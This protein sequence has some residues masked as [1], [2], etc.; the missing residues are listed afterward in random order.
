MNVKF[1][2][3]CLY[4]NNTWHDW[5]YYLLF[6]YLWWL[7]KKGK[8]EYI[9]LYFQMIVSFNIIAWY[10]FAVSIFII[11]LICDSIFCVYAWNMPTVLLVRNNYNC[12]FVI[13]H[14][15][16]ANVKNLVDSFSSHLIL[17]WH[18]FYR[19][20]I[21]ISFLFSVLVLWV[22]AL[23]GCIPIYFYIPTSQNT[24]SIPQDINSSMWVTLIQV[25]YIYIW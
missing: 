23:N 22:F 24:C 16:Y 12:F 4:I 10:E 20:Y 14:T 13:L 15:N 8:K 19:F 3:Y 18:Y 11:H 1:S 25:I 17:C 6:R 7:T 9:Y 21:H 2:D 5:F